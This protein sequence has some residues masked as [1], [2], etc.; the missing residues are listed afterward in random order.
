MLL[1]VGILAGLVS[2]ASA[3]FVGT[4]G[5]TYMRDLGTEEPVWGSYRQ[6]DA[7]EA[8]IKPNTNTQLWGDV[9]PGSTGSE[10]LCKW[11]AGSQNSGR[12][13]CKTD[14][15]WLHSA[16]GIQK[17]FFND[18][19]VNYILRFH[20]PAACYRSTQVRSALL[21][22]VELQEILKPWERAECWMFL[23]CVDSCRMRPIN[24]LIEFGE[25]R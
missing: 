5:Q 9:S 22:T 12:G 10:P 15:S 3:N 19:V 7:T 4:V 14:I 17:S 20:L 1:S 16:V 6:G 24:A 11:T 13:T 25:A 23:D 8:A 21:H 18:D 2:N